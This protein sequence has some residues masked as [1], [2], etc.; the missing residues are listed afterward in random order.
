MLDW[1]TI[2]TV[3]LDMDGTLLDLHFDNFFWLTH[4]PKR[5]A[6]E[7]NTTEE[8]ALQFIES[9]VRKYEGTLNWYCLDH[10]SDLVKM[11]VPALKKEISHKI[12]ARPYAEQFLKTMKRVGKKS[13]LIT[14]AHPKGLELKLDITEIDRWLDL[15]ISS[16]EFKT[17]KE[18]QAFW[19]Q[20]SDR[21]HFDPE[22]S[23]FIDD[24]P[25]VLK[26]AQEFGIKHLVCIIQPDSQKPA[27]A[28]NEFIDIT[29][30]NE[31][32][33]EEVNQGRE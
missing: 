21:E 18:D 27:K 13:I 28:T 17:P 24:T 31:I 19:Q 5:Y 10:W 20:L 9:H 30:F 14:N 29:H 22:R 1:N 25:R 33:P 32:F 15:V 23:V 6:Q 16:H 7:H 8:D 2:D 11:D 3:L 12:Q 26:S 4:L